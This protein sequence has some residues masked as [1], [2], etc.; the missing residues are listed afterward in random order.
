MASHGGL[1]MHL[2]ELRLLDPP[3]F[4]QTCRQNH[5]HYHCPLKRNTLEPPSPGPLADCGVDDQ[6]LGLEIGAGVM[7]HL[8]RRRNCVRNGRSGTASRTDRQEGWSVSSVGC[9]IYPS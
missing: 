3:L 6:E 1:H 9:S 2:A 7:A 4:V 5:G 8:P